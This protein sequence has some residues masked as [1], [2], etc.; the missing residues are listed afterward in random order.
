MSSPRGSKTGFLILLEPQ[1]TG[2]Q[3]KHGK[4]WCQASSLVTLTVIKHKLP[5]S[6]IRMC[7]GGSWLYWPTLL[8]PSGNTE[9]LQ[10]LVQFKGGFPGKDY[11]W[12][13]PKMLWVHRLTKVNPVRG[14]A[15]QGTVA[16]TLWL[17][18]DAVDWVSERP[19]NLWRF[20]QHSFSVNE[21]PLL[22]L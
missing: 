4:R 2:S 7:F 9:A 19:C 6:M 5:A 16:G 3:P 14:Q 12:G 11:G 20:G 8:K 10:C 22:Q 15:A 13:D 21:A 17:I 18:E 1:N